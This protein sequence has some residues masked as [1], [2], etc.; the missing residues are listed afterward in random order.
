MADHLTHI[1]GDFK[2]VFQ[3]DG[4]GFAVNLLHCR[5]TGAESSMHR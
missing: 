5:S 2:R 4:E 3:M 1:A